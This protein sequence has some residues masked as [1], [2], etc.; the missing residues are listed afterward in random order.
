MNPR[1]EIEIKL[2]VERR[3]ALEERLSLLGFRE[4]RGRHFES[5]CLFDFSDRRLY[6]AGRLVRLR[7]ANGEGILTFKGPAVRSGLY[8]IREEVETR[9]EDASL[10]AKI[11]EGIG[12]IEVFRYEKY[13]TVYGRVGPEF[14]GHRGG[15]ADARGNLRRSLRPE[16]P[17][18]LYDETPIGDYVELE[19]PERWIDEIARQLG[20][21]RGEY[22][23]ASYGRLYREH[24]ES[25]GKKSGDMLFAT[26][27]RASR[28]GPK[29]ARKS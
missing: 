27:K 21:G 6:K 7:W 4:L 18:L 23:T 13:R 24:C 15:Q 2:R 25:R 29:L 22:I 28:P 1:H 17:K 12:L 9:V 3:R 10:L 20:Y 5:N 16:G 8:K 14:E 19:G 26:P 11:L